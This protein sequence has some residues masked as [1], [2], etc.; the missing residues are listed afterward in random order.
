MGTD[1]SAKQPMIMRRH[2]QI[3]RSDVLF[4]ASRNFMTSS[5]SER[6]C[7]MDK[8]VCRKRMYAIHRD[9]YEHKD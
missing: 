7:Q 8:C 5:C 9:R 4:S 3:C 1:K 2:N 6:R